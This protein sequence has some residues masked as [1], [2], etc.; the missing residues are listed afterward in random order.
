MSSVYAD[1]IVDITNEKLV[2]LY[3]RRNVIRIVDW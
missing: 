3:Y 1:V 2:D